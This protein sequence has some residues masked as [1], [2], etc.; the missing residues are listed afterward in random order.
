MAHD[1]VYFVKNERRNPELRYSL[2]SV[3]ENVEY[4]KVWFYG[5]CPEGIVPDEWIRVDQT[6]PKKW[7]RV[8]DM[9]K[10]ACEND[11]I[12]DQFWLFNDDFFILKPLDETACYYD[13]TLTSKI[14]ET[15][16]RHGGPSEWTRN[17]RRLRRLLQDEGLPELCYAVHRPML[18]D[19]AKA[20]VVLEKFPDEPMFRALYGNYY[21]L[22]G[23]DS[24]DVKISYNI[25]GIADQ[26]PDM[27]MVSTSDES[28][29]RLYVGRWLRERFSVNSRFENG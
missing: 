20:L 9:L 10:M 21:E 8:R 23:I 3:E 5:G 16:K 4:R 29:K 1:I 15:E 14:E 13:G 17:M 19:R 7:Q 18:V 25:N 12:T 28:F 27:D 11:D 22:G 26:L 6:A 2:R 24:P